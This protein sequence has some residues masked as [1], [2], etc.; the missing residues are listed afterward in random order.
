MIH[1]I[2]LKSKPKKK[3]HLMSVVA[4]PEMANYEL[5]LVKQQ[6]IAEGNEDAQVAIQFFDSVFWIPEY[7]AELKEHKP[8][9]N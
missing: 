2:Y 9:F 6:A 4:S 7:I 1:G 3:W 5:D 8:Q